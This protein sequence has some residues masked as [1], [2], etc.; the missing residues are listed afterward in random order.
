MNKFLRK[1]NYFKNSLFNNQ[2]VEI[3]KIKIDVSHEIFSKKHRY[4]ILS[5]GYERHPIRILKKTINKKDIFLECGSG[6]G[7]ITLNICKYLNYN[8]VFSIEANPTL[9]KIAKLN[10]ELNNINP[11]IFN[12]A[13]HHEKGEILTFFSKNN[14]FL[15]SYNYKNESSKYNDNQ[16]TI[17]TLSLETIIKENNISYLFLNIEGGEYDCIMN[18]KINNLKKLLVLY[19]LKKTTLD[20]K[21][22]LEKKLSSIGLVSKLKLRDRLVYYENVNSHQ[23]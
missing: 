8:Q 4:D 16:F 11:H 1:I 9:V 23:T 6:I 20:K 7:F 13:I 19:D 17:E 22:D 5:G 12:Y 14:D 21:N 10:F 18:S 15:T 2:I 3:N